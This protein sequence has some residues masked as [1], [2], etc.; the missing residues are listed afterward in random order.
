MALADTWRLQPADANQSS[1]QD[2]DWKAVS[3]EG[4][5]KFL[6][7]VAQIKTL[8]NTGQTEAVRN[9]FDQLKKDFPEIAGPDLDAFI[10]AELFFCEGNFTKAVKAYDKLL[11]GFP[12]SKLSE[13][14][15]SRQFEI[16]TAFLAG[17]KKTVFRVFKLSR[18][19]EG[20]KIMEKISTR[21]GLDAQIGLKAA[22][23]LTS[24]FEKRQRFEDAYLK[25]WEISQQ[26]QA[27]MVGKDAITAMA[28]CKRAAYNK[29]DEESRHLYD[30]SRL[31]TSKSYYN[32]LESL[33]PEDAQKI[34]V[35]EIV[36]DIDEQLAAKQLSIAQYYQKTGNLQ[37]ANLYYD[38]VKNDWPQTKAAEMAKPAVENKK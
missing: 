18:Y 38:I 33:Y 23:S 5:D 4:Q 14:A 13:A 36:K 32:K 11:D 35:D 22:L 27:G 7:A 9:E 17:Q 21:A 24:S 16:A 10:E 19:D 1:G 3:P 30:T 12:D 2:D 37:A 31:I 6:L 25:W 8:V 15:L 34:G 26:W 20:V 28:R 29:Q